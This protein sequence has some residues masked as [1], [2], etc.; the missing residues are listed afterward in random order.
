MKQER[1][2][3]ITKNEDTLAFLDVLREIFIHKKEGED[4]LIWGYLP[5]RTC[6]IKEAYGIK[7][8]N[9][10]EREEIWQKI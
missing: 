1:W 9:E 7:T 3:I 8:R 2:E 4:K 5:K 10:E 6:R